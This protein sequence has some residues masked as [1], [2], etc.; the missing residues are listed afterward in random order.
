MLFVLMC[1]IVPVVFMGINDCGV[2]DMDDLESIVETVGDAVHDLYVKA[3]ARN[4]VLI[5]V[6]PINRSPQ[7]ALS[8]P[9]PRL[10]LL[11]DSLSKSYRRGDPRRDRGASEDMER[12]P[13]G[14]DN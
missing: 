9:H 7:G 12:A 10:E 13:A 6:P 2:N 14:A 1:S 8:Q 4:L 3:G 5:D 11:T